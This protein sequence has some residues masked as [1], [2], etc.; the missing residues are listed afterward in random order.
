ML[1]TF[2]L[3]RLLKRMGMDN[4]GLKTFN[5]ANTTSVITYACPAWDNLLSDSEKNKTRK[6]SV[7]CLLYYAAILCWLATEAL[8]SST[9]NHYNFPAHLLQWTLHPLNSRISI[10]KNRKSAC[11]G[12]RDKYKL[13]KCKT[14]KRQNTFWIEFYM[15]FFNYC[16]SDIYVPYIQCYQPSTGWI[17]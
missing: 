17:I 6:D 11:W 1:P 8:R 12:K 15:Q 7:L 5:V 13:S 14:T 10:N 3:M 9:A 2:I 4:K 16:C